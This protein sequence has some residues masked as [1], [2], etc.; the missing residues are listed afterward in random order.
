MQSVSEIDCHPRLRQLLE[1]RA[2][3]KSFTWLAM[4][5]SE[6]AKPVKLFSDD[7]FIHRLY[8]KLDRKLMREKTTKTVR[9]WWKG[10]RQCYTGKP[11]EMKASQIYPPK[12]GT[13]V[14]CG[15]ER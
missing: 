1:S 15:K 12:F 3:Q 7:A 5:G 8:R 14:P 6:T 11:K 9:R 2:L 13:Q 4:F 10:N